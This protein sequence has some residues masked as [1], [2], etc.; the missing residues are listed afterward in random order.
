MMAVLKKDYVLTEILNAFEEGKTISDVSNWLGIEETVLMAIHEVFDTG[1]KWGQ[2]L[3]D[4]DIV[5][6]YKSGLTFSEVSWIKGVTKEAIRLTVDSV[7]L[8]GKKYAKEE[9]KRNRVEMRNI[10]LYQMVVVEADETSVEAAV[11]KTGYSKEVFK[12]LYRESVK[13]KKSQE[14]SEKKEEYIG[15]NELVLQE[16]VDTN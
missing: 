14:E 3:T 9:S 2:V 6:F 5:D 7:L 8:D 13:W 11:E 12:R 16:K 1:N 15:D 4:F 10:I